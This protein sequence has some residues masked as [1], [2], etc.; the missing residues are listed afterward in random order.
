MNQLFN[1][2][3]TFHYKKY[4]EVK[5]TMKV[6]GS[7]GAEGSNRGQGLGKESWSR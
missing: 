3:L 2:L 6:N 1:K 4:M 7:G 5:G